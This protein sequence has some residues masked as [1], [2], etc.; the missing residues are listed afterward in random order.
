MLG[1]HEGL[2]AAGLDIFRGAWSCSGIEKA[3]Q[4]LGPAEFGDDI[5]DWSLIGLADFA[6][7][8]H[9]DEDRNGFWR[10]SRFQGE[11][12]LFGLAIEIDFAGRESWLPIGLK[13]AGGLPKG[14]VEPLICFELESAHG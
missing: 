1:V 11:C 4:V 3:L 9:L 12:H 6:L 14:V 8:E 5:K 13:L 2:Q 10:S 7:A